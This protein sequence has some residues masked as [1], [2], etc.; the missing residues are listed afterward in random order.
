MFGDG[1]NS[2]EHEG[3]YS[4]ITIFQ[5]I[6]FEFVNDIVGI[7]KR[8]RKGYTPKVLF[9]CLLLMYLQQISSINRLIIKLQ[10][11]L[12]LARAI[13]LPIKNG[14]PQVPNRTTFTKFLNRI[15]PLKFLEI[16]LTLVSKLLENKIIT[17]EEIAIDCTIIKA[18][19]NIYRKQKSDKQARWGYQYRESSKVIWIYGYKVH[20]IVDAKTD[21]P[22]AFKVTPAN[23][24]EGKLLIP[25]LQQIQQLSLNIKRVLADAAYDFNTNRK[26]IIAMFKAIAVIAINIRNCKGK[27]TMEKKARRI[28]RLK[29]WYRK[30]NLQPYFLDP[31]SQGFKTYYKKRSSSERNNSNGKGELRLNDLKWQG[32]ERATIHASLSLSARLAVALTAAQVG[33]TDLINS[34]KCFTA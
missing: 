9:Q 33:R 8:G 16:F 26:A 5:Q 11:N 21:L 1:S 17:G 23:Q 3:T 18:W 32:L 19:C 2:G 10:H 29:K 14:K 25:M 27:N 20:I 13:G 6:D 7:N 28:K 12:E 30:N 15:G 24:S 22:I 34:P 31:K 4:V